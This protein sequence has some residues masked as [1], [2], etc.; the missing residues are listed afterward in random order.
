MKCGVCKRATCGYVIEGVNYCQ[1]CLKHEIKTD[2]K[3][4]LSDLSA[5]EDVDLKYNLYTLNNILLKMTNFL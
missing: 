1:S 5:Y 2:I 4:L 3:S